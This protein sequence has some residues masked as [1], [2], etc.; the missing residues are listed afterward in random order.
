L[1]P[2][3]NPIP[4]G[5]REFRIFCVEDNALLLMDLQ[6]MIEECGFV[7]AG[8]AA[9]FA[10]V[11]AQFATVPFDLALVDIDLADGRTGGDV[12]EWLSAHSRPSV[13]VTGQEQLAAAYAHASL[14]ILVKPVD[15]HRLKALL[16]AVV[17][18]LGS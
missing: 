6:I 4:S 14:G 5:Q 15:E 18:R 10:D 7:F 13:F 8:S 11:K 16:H 1:H 2:S 12:A 17:E 3:S 9:R